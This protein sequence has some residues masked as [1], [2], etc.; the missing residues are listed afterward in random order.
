MLTFEYTDAKG[1]VVQKTVRDNFANDNIIDDLLNIKGAIEVKTPGSVV[2]VGGNVTSERDKEAIK[3][4][5]ALK[6]PLKLRHQE[7]W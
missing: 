7:V 2:N 4:Q 1:D 3:R 6:E 5:Y